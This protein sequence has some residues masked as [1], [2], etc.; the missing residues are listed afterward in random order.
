MEWSGVVAVGCGES[1]MK[2]V[3]WTEAERG[4]EV[5]GDWTM[6]WSVPTHHPGHSWVMGGRKYE[7]S[8]V[9]NSVEMRTV[10]P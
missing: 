2:L 4:E 1:E 7:E 9:E 3:V 10:K 8:L 5:G 6:V